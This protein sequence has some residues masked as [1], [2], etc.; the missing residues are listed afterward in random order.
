M[1][2]NELK[3]KIIKEKDDIIQNDK[4]KINQLEKEMENLNNIEMNQ[5]LMSERYENKLIH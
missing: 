1:K 5:K 2:N 3:D 4:I